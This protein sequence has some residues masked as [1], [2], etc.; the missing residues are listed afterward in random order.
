MEPGKLQHS[1]GQ[2]W[3]LSR[4]VARS[5]FQHSPS[6]VG[7]L[8]KDVQSRSARFTQTLVL[9]L[10]KK[11]CAPSSED[12]LTCRRW[13]LLDSSIGRLPH[14]DIPSQLLIPNG[15]RQQGEPTSKG[16]SERIPWNFH[17][18]KPSPLTAKNQWIKHGGRL[19]QIIVESRTFKSKVAR[20]TS[21][22]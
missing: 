8:S 7:A 20:I 19:M 16:S 18:K 5:D 11:T 13:K 1:K 17:F 9:S 12:L 10:E 21:D 22:V 2:G 4:M 15:I 6:G 14:S 3:I